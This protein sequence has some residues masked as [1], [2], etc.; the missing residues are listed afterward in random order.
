MKRE[1]P[2]EFMQ[3]LDNH[4]VR[5]RLPPLQRR[6]MV[7]PYRLRKFEGAKRLRLGN[8]GAFLTAP[9]PDLNIGFS[10]ML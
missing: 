9:I 2:I 3:T 1:L 7:R 10:F 8:S 6:G 4:P 5:L